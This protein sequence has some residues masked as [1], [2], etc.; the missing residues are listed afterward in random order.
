SAR[1]GVAQV[2][3]LDL[4]LRWTDKIIRRR[5]LQPVKRRVD[6]ADCASE[7]HAVIGS[8]VA[9]RKGQAGY[10]V[11][12]EQTIGG[13]QRDLH[14]RVSA[15]DVRDRNLIRVDR[16]KENRAVLNHCLWAGNCVDWWIVDCCQSD[17]KVSHE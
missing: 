6:V 8:T 10:A 17:Q 3:G 11:Q 2:I 12:G 1:S 13:T 15:I 5:E 14:R 7:R 9:R 4:N 16:R